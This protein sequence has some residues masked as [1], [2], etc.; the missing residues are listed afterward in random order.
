LIPSSIGNTS[1]QCCHWFF[2]FASLVS[3]A[4]VVTEPIVYT[5]SGTIS[6][7]LGLTALTNAPFV[8]TVV[9]GT[10]GVTTFDLPPGV[11]QNQETVLQH[12]SASSVYVSGVGNASVS[13]LVQQSV[14]H[15]A[16]HGT[17]S[18][19]NVASTFGMTIT[20]PRDL[21]GWFLA[22]PIGPITGS[23]TFVSTA[24]LNTSLGALT[25]TGVSNLSFQAQYNPVFP[26]LVMG[27]LGGDV[28][29]TAIILNNTTTALASFAMG[30]FQD[31]GQPLSVASGYFDENSIAPITNNG[32]NVAGTLSPMSTATI[33]LSSAAFEEGWAT[34]V[35][36]GITG[37]V[38]FH[39]HT[40]SGADYEATVPLSSGGTEFFV[41]YDATSY[42]NGTSFVTSLPY[43][44]GMALVNLDTANPATISCTILNQNGNGVGAGTA[45]TLPPLGHTALQLNVA[46]GYANLAGNLGTLDCA[47]GGATFA[48]LGLRFL[49]SNDLT[50]FAA[51][52]IQ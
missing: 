6:G 26:H 48:V 9:A 38:V 12:G 52:K 4:A 11:Y 20:D 30:F 49:G 13:D 50:S 39:R 28:W 40:S 44:T 3:A 35:G 27:P 31:G 24:P 45:V 21:N 43:I 15:T 37:Q 36:P 16:G 8:W 51:I 32:T 33:V 22:N 5:F 10:G 29:T 7:T 17:I 47:S 42:F 41:P 1:F 14:D 18:M 25:V 46:S 23:A 19:A 2:I 34:L